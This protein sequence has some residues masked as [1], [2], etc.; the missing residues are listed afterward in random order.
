MLIVPLFI[1]S[2]QTFT[3][4][5]QFRTWW[6]DVS[7]LWRVSLVFRTSLLHNSVARGLANPF[8]PS[9]RTTFL[10]D[11]LLVHSLEHRLKSPYDRGSI[12]GT[13]PSRTANKE[14]TEIVGKVNVAVE[15]VIHQ[16]GPIVRLLRLEEGLDARAPFTE[17][18]IALKPKF[19]FED[20]CAIA[21]PA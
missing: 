9:D 5:H 18:K 11:S 20:T 15:D 7:T 8:T 12:I 2:F 17:F 21:C 14:Y 16:V 19:F 4:L 10:A 13:R 3:S 6:C 1:P